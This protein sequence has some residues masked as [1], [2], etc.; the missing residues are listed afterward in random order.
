MASKKARLSETER[1][2][3]G[4]FFRATIISGKKRKNERMSE[5]LEMAN[6]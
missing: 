3:F 2:V 5:K 4:I 1:K 6:N